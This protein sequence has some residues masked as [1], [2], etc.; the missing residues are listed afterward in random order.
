MH[1]RCHQPCL[2]F[3]GSGDHLFKF[4]QPRAFQCLEEASNVVTA[5]KALRNRDGFQHHVHSQPRQG[6]TEH[7]PAYPLAE[8]YQQQPVTYSDNIPSNSTSTT[9]APP[10]P[11]P[12]AQ[13]QQ[14]QPAY[15]IHPPPTPNPSAQQQQPQPYDNDNVYQITISQPSFSSS[16]SATNT[17]TTSTQ[18]QTPTHPIGPFLSDPT[19]LYPQPHHHHHHHHPYPATLTQ[20]A[21]IYPPAQMAYPTTVSLDNFSAD[22][23]Y[24]IPPGMWP[25]NIVQ[26]QHGGM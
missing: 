25:V 22:N 20:P 10:L 26:Y 2:P 16:T 1:A 24:S 13:E 23:I 7:P 6:E 18:A 5:S 14:Q 17:T 21:S 8:S 9:T 4:F 12:S 3:T 15:N 11:M 19:T